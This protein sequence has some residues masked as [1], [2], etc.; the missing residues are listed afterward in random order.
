ML[1]AW[2]TTLLRTEI[3]WGFDCTFS[4]YANDCKIFVSQCRACA[5]S[6][7]GTSVILNTHLLK[8]DKITKKDRR[9]M[10]VLSVLN[11]LIMS[12]ITCRLCRRIRRRFPF[13]GFLARGARSG[14]DKFGYSAWLNALFVFHNFYYLLDTL[15]TLKWGPCMI[16][17][18]WIEEH[19][20]P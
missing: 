12:I 14:M 13:L 8:F 20:H 5:V 15:R 17:A 3:T 16:H 4:L 9:I 18:T 2:P 10:I 19:F 11:N 6:N 7:G 1:I